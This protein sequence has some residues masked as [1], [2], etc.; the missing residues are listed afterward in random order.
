M[1]EVNRMKVQ[2][3]EREEAV[4]YPQIVIQTTVDRDCGWQ[5]VDVDDDEQRLCRKVMI[6]YV[7]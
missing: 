6:K 4:P 1:V 2:L 3:P 7:V 5:L